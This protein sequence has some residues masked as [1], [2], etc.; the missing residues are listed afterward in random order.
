[1]AALF[2]GNVIQHMKQV[3]VRPT[4][5]ECIPY[6]PTFVL[7]VKNYLE[8]SIHSFLR[9]FLSTKIFVVTLNKFKVLVNKGD[10]LPQRAISKS[11]SVIREKEK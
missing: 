8:N 1:M 3:Q 9:F 7:F 5:L 4:S 2:S 11:A 6:C 10:S